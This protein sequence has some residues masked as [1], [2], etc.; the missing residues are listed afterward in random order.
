MHCR[1]RCISECDIVFKTASGCRNFPYGREAY[2]GFRPDVIGKCM[3]SIS[4]QSQE[5]ESSSCVVR[6]SENF[7]LLSYV[8]CFSLNIFSCKFDVNALSSEC[9]VS[10]EFHDLYESVDQVK[11]VEY[12]L[13]VK[14]DAEPKHIP[15]RR[16]PP[17]MVEKISAQLQKMQNDSIIIPAETSDWSYL[18]IAVLERMIKYV[19][20]QISVIS[21]VFLRGSI[22]RFQ[23]LKNCS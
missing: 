6:S 20:A 5:C 4:Y 17:A 21:I 13:R 11:H 23:L 15:P 10:N 8:T 3:L 19:F 7:P 14:S 12:E 2:G 9:I 22:S 16:V 18:M 1:Y